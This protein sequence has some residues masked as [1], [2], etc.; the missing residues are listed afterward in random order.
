MVKEPIP[1][2]PKTNP[3][4]LTQLKPIP[5]LTEVRKTNEQIGAD[6]LSSFEAVRQVYTEGGVGGLATSIKSSYES[7]PSNYIYALPADGKQCLIL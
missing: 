7:Y 5:N 2:Q 1:K 3:T 4:Y 6:N